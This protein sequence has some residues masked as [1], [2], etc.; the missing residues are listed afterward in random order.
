VA[1]ISAAAPNGRSEMRKGETG[2]RLM[3]RYPAATDEG[4]DT[5]D[6][7]ML[8]IARILPLSSIGIASACKVAREGV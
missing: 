6:G 8:N 1:K 2:E 5:N 4:R 7:R 3:Y